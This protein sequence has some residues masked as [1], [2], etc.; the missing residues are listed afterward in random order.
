[1]EN[2]KIYNTPFE[3]GV[4]VLLLLKEF[5]S[6]LDIQQIMILDYFLL[7]LGDLDNNFESLHPAN[8][9]HITELFSKRKLIQEAVLLLVRKGLAVCD[10]DSKGIRYKNANIGESFLNYFESEYFILL[11]NNA[12]VL[13]NRFNENKIDK[14]DSYLK[15]SLENRKD[16]FEFEALFRGE[17]L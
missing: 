13:T 3:V 14:L 1:M 16:E 17:E 10:Y 6:S 15:S 11:K 8:P 7:H 2:I 12:M 4:R 9:Y 5:K